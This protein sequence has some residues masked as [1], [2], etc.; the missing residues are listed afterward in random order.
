MASAT[1]SLA[2]ARRVEVGGEVEEPESLPIDRLSQ[3]GTQRGAYL[4]SLKTSLG[5]LRPKARTGSGEFDLNS[6]RF[7]GNRGWRML[8]V[9]GTWGVQG[10]G[11]STC[12]F[13]ESTIS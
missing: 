12:C 6:H 11:L 9:F 3:F 1:L 10:A 13:K 5:G 8:W 2:C 7:T 4:R